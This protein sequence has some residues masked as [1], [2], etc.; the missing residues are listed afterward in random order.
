MSKSVIDLDKMSKP[1]TEL[2]RYDTMRVPCHRTV[3]CTTVFLDVIVGTKILDFIPS[4]LRLCRNEL[5]RYR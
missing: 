5:K 3:L 1:K 2:S 4:R